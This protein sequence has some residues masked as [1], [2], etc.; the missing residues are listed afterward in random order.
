[1]SHNCCHLLRSCYSVPPLS[2]IVH[3]FNPISFEDGFCLPSSYHSSTWL[4]D[5]FQ[6]TCN[7][8]TS[9]QLA[10]CD[11]NLSTEDSCVQSACRP[12]DTQTMCTNSKPGERMACQAGTASTSLECVTHSSQSENSQQTGHTVWSCQPGS[13]RTRNY[14]PKTYVS[15]TYQTLECESSQIHSQSSESSSCTDLVYVRPEPQLLESCSIYEPTCCV[16]GGLQ[17]PSK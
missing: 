13:Y 16:T 2:A 4:L 6:E 12:R 11:Q 5:S 17:L 15:K 10:N 14:S 8:T 3:G 7:E 9:C 1:M